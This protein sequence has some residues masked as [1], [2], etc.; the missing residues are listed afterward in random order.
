VIFS[1]RLPPLSLLSGHLRNYSKTRKGQ[2]C[3][4]KVS[5]LSFHVSS[6][7][8]YQSVSAKIGRSG[9]E[10]RPAI[11]SH[12]APP[13]YV[14]PAAPPKPP[15][16]VP[17]EVPSESAASFLDLPP[18]AEPPVLFFC[19]SIIF[20]V[21]IFSPFKRFRCNHGCFC[22]ISKTVGRFG[23]FRTMFSLRTEVSAGGVI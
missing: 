14:P 18:E 13:S 16:Y 22:Y 23:R 8:V 12:P 6:A 21:N 17:P 9:Q 2:S 1:R 10:S 20:L 19:C 3:I 11:P 7:P 5:F 15:P 4:Q